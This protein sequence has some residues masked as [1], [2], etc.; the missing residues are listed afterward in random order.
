MPV[1][2][3]SGDDAGQAAAFGNDVS[4]D[5]WACLVADGSG[6]AVTVARRS[7]QAEHDVAKATP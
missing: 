3:P 2:S 4:N 6:G 1:L 7:M 5:T